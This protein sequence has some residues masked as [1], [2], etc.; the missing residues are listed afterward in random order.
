MGSDP[1]DRTV[2]QRLVGLGVVPLGDQLAS[3]LSSS[4]SSSS[5]QLVNR[6]TFSSADLVFGHALAA[7]PSA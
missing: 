2:Y 5:A 7:E 4:R 3:G 6:A 1:G